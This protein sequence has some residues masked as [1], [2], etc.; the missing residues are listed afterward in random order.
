MDMGSDAYALAVAPVRAKGERHAGEPEPVLV[1]RFAG[2]EFEE[3]GFPLQERP[4]LFIEVAVLPIDSAEE[5]RRFAVTTG[6]LGEFGESEA[7]I[8]GKWRPAEPISRW[9][10]CARLLRALIQLWQASRLADPEEALGR[11][12]HWRHCEVSGWYFGNLEAGGRILWL[13]VRVGEEARPDGA[14]LVAAAND[15]LATAINRFAKVGLSL[16]TKDRSS[17]WQLGLQPANLEAGIFLQ[18]ALAVTGSVNYGTCIIC[19][20]WFP[21]PD[22]RY[23]PGAKRRDSEHCSATCRQRA[24][25]R[26]ARPTVKG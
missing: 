12:L 8:N 5:I 26:R 2:V 13:P 23:F 1:P 19:G 18:F 22:G 24:K 3:W 9:T 17:G 14:E 7:R 11:L 15:V 6:P 10:W 20:K 21:R 25:R 4:A 16:Q